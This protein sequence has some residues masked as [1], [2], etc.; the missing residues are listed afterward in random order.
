[1][2]QYRIKY[3]ELPICQ[4]QSYQQTKWSE[5]RSIAH[6]PVEENILMIEFRQAMT[7]QE[8]KDFFKNYEVVWCSQKIN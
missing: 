3:A 4:L 5:W 7:V 8:A 1:M 2:K 6:P